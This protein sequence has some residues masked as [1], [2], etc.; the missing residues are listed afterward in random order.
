MAHPTFPFSDPATQLH[1]ISVV[2][3]PMRYASRVRLYHEFAERMKC[4]GVHLI[5]VEQAFGDRPFEVTQAG[6][7]DHV[8]T[9]SFDALWIKEKLVNIGI[10]HLSQQ[11][12]NWG[13]VAWIDADVS[14]ANPNWVAD[15]IHALQHNMFV[16]LFSHAVDLGPKNEIIKNHTGFFYQYAQN[17]FQTPGTASFKK[18]GTWHPG[19]GHA[20]RR[21]AV[22]AVGMLLDWAILGA[23]DRHMCTA[24]VG[25]VETSVP[26]NINAR[27][28][29][30]LV[31]WQDRCEQFIKRD[32]G[33][34]DGVLLHHWHGRKSS[35]KYTERWQILI[36]NDYDPD[37][38][39][40]LDTYGQWQLTGNKPRLRDQIRAYFSQRSEDSI[41]L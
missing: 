24:M 39:I 32:V 37:T 34:V 11:V 35:R 3:N 5:T 12:P 20:A 25:A 2:S 31:R 22:E 30:E 7:P 40:K 41:D 27:Y 33:Y 9:R 21:E 4:A 26:P 16:Q 38:D 23:G 15:T 8:Q 18:Y 36:D 19:F 6:N 29:A 13:Y 10:T 17:G 28:L 14:F 1:V